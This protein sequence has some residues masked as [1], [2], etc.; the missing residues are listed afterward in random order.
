MFGAALLAP[1]FGAPALGVATQG[2]LAGGSV[3]VPVVLTGASGATALQFDVAYDAT[4]LIPNSAI[5]GAFPAHLAVSSPQTNNTIRIVLY[6]PSNSPLPDGTLVTIP[7]AIS[8]SAKVASLRLSLKNVIIADFQGNQIAT[9]QL[10]DG[11]VNVVTVAAAR[12]SSIT[13]AINGDVTF[14]LFGT[15]GQSYIIQASRDFILWPP[16]STNALLNSSIQVTDPSAKG[17][18]FRFY[19]AVQVP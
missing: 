19:R 11:A 4:V 1:A 18:P 12:L 10:T 16:I 5:L 6:S 14:Q 9:G 3:G 15:A 2:G 17:F 8:S 7:F 13:R